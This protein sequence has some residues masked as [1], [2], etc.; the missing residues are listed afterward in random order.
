MNDAYYTET[1]ERPDL[2]AIEVNPPEGYIGTKIMP[3]VPVSEKTGTIYY[4]TVIADAAAETGRAAGAAPSA[5]AISDSNTTFTAAEAVKRGTITPDEAKT[6]G[7]IEKADAVGAKWGKRQVMNAIESAIATVVLGGAVDDA[8]DSAKLLDD[9]QTALDA[10][11]LYE[12]RTALVSSPMVLKR[13]VRNMLQDVNY[14]PM[15]S[16]LIAGGSP[17]QAATGMNFKSWM[18]G[19]AMFLGVDEILAGDDTIWN[20]GT[21]AERFAFCKLD[22]G[23][24]ELSHK[25]KPVLGKTFQFMPDGSN[26]WVIQAVADRVNVNN[27][28]D[29]YSWYNVVTLNATA[30]Y[31]FDGVAA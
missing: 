26:P 11:R 9:S 31:L 3:I 13:I 19:L 16:R 22:D 30:I 4:A 2:A 5:S 21:N 28:Y 29:A 14:G 10:I 23:A 18:T 6:M 15:F 1:G 27:L 8:F 7:G 24:D 12:G 25:W 20:A 17:A